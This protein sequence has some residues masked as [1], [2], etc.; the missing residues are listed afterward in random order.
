MK[1]ISILIKALQ[2]SEIPE[3]PIED[4]ILVCAGRSEGRRLLQQCAAKGAC[5]IGVTAESPMSLAMDVCSAMLAEHNAPRLISDNEAA[6]LILNLLTNTTQGYYNTDTAQTLTVAKELLKTFYELDMACSGT[7]SGTPK[8]DATQALRLRYAEK[9]KEQNILDRIDLLKKACEV[10]VP[11]GRRYVALSSYAPTPLEKQLLENLSGGHLVIAPISAPAEIS[12]TE[13]MLDKNVPTAA[14]PQDLNG[15]SRFYP[16][17]GMDTEV[18]FVFRDILENSSS[19]GDCAVIYLSGEYAQLIHET[20]ARFHIPVNMSAGIP[21]TGSGIFAMLSQLITL[22]QAN[23]D[24]EKL[25]VLL[26]NGICKPH[27]YYRLAGALRDNRVG[28]GKDRYLRFLDTIKDPG[29]EK[30]SEYADKWT[31]FFT[32]LF[33]VL[34]PSGSLSDQKQKLL[35]FLRRYTNRTRHGE[36]AAYACAQKL[37]GEISSL[38][39]DETVAQR[40]VELMKSCNY[41]NSPPQPGQL[42]CVP[43]SQA[44]YTGRKKL[45]ILG[46]SRY[47]LQGANRES[48]ILNDAVRKHLGLRNA[49]TSENENTFRLL[50][51]VLQH[52]GEFVFCYPNFDSERM[53]DQQPSP[54]YNDLKK[55]AN[56]DETIISYVP[57][58]PLTAGDHMLQGISAG[59]YTA[60]WNSH[61]AE[62]LQQAVPHRQLI[63]NFPFSSSSLETAFQ[64]PLRFYL[65][66]ILHFYKPDVPQ[67][68]DSSWLPK[69]EMGTFCHHV[70][71]KYYQAI[72][73]QET[74]D[75]DALIQQECAEIEKRNPVTRKDLQEKDLE[76]ARTMI[77]NTISWTSAEGRTVRSTEHPFGKNVG[78]DPPPSPI[79]LAINSKTLLLSGSIDR[80]DEKN[81]KLSILDYKTGDADRFEREKDY[82]LQHYLY[83]LAAEQLFNCKIEDAGYLFL[84]TSSGIKFESIEENATR[85]AQMALAVETL[86]EWLADE[87]KCTSHIPCPAPSSGSTSTGSIAP[88][89][90]CSRYCP[91]KDFCQK[92]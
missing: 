7:L 49:Q 70:L 77:E 3:R 65:E 90:N 51:A 72:M 41:L 38:R 16:C 13:N 48:P 75:L 57:G 73:N 4:V 8:L 15:R 79:S 36:A 67:Y 20:A 83:T 80:I 18:R 17:R 71:E 92:Q 88:K 10:N 14:I 40:L 85:R 39:P 62:P 23:Y 27:K 74:P 68:S 81:Q 34:E 35:D 58:T 59:N 64:C 5:L 25:C 2:G 61:D 45:Y 89:D 46:L 91:Y 43:L 24:T 44:L 47:A 31:E 19:A 63:A 29:N 11:D 76:K 22:P 26:D 28:W 66:R 87:E 1:D 9:K 33:S 52:E 42:F 12:P 55:A 54:F 50:Q 60:Q 69:N 84:N 30:L 56:A 53:L 6:E 37:V 86:L 78:G 82:H 21:M 32:A